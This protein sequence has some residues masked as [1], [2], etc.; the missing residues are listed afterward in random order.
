MGT[1]PDGSQLT[2]RGEAAQVWRRLALG[3]RLLQPGDAHHE[4][5]VQIRRRDGGKP[6][7]LE[8]R[9]RSIRRFLEDALVECQP[10]QLAVEEQAVTARRVRH[11]ST[12]AG[13]TTSLRPNT[14]TNMSL[15][16]VAAICSIVM[17]PEPSTSSTHDFSSR[18][19]CRS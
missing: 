1:L 3:D 5:L 11:P 14:S 9:D 19:R 7:P 13:R 16:A 2:L 4:E 6:D 18:N 17:S 10:R 8:E 12:P 15:R